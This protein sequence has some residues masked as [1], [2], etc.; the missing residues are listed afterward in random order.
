[1]IRPE[2]A[3]KLAE[4]V[5]CL[6]RLC[7]DLEVAALARFISLSVKTDEVKQQLEAA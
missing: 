1:M 3:Q 7:P 2:A 6:T 4:E 5:L